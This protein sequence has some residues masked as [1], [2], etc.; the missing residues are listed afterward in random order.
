MLYTYSNYK[1]TVIII[2]YIYL[3]TFLCPSH[4]YKTVGPLGLWVTQLAFPA[5]WKIYNTSCENLLYFPRY[6][7]ET[8]INFYTFVSMRTRQWVVRNDWLN[9][10]YYSKYLFISSAG[11]LAQRYVSRLPCRRFSV[12][13]WSGRQVSVHFFSFGK[14]FLQDKIIQIFGCVF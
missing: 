8:S 5:W 11:A 10:E 2:M 3:N 9:L 12:R 7:N 14:S 6:E 4:L 1:Y 13:N